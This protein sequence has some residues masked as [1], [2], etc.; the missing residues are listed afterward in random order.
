[1]SPSR[2]APE[3]PDK[4]TLSKLNEM[5]RDPE[6]YSDE[7]IAVYLREPD[8]KQ[9]SSNF[10]PALEV[11]TDLVDD[12]G[13]EADVA[14]A[15]LNRADRARRH[16]R[17]RSKIAGGYQGIRIV[18]EGDSWFQYPFILKDTIDWLMEAYAVY[19]LGAAGDLVADM[20]LQDEMRDAI[21]QHRPDVF[22]ISGGGNDLLGDGRLKLAVKTYRAGRPASEYPNANFDASIRDVIADYRRIFRDLTQEFPDL[23]II[24]HGYDY[25]LP[26]NGRWLGKPLAAKGITD[27]MLQAGIIAEMI[28]RF[29]Q[30]LA[31]LAQEFPGRVFR[32]NCRGAVGKNDWHDELHPD[33]KG[34]AAVANRFHA[35]IESVAG[36]VEAERAKPAPLSPGYDKRIAGAKDLDPLSFRELVDHRARELLA[37]PIE[38]TEDEDERRHIE[39]EIAQHFE[40]ISGGADFLPAGFLRD[41]A[42]RA[43]AVCRISTPTS[44]G[45]GFLVATRDFVMTNNHVLASEAEA[46]ESVAEF[47]LEHD[48]TGVRVALQPKRFFVTDETLDFTIVACD[49]SGVPADV[50]PIPLL[51]S[52]STVTRG[53]KVNIVQHPRGRPKEVA[54]HNNDVMRVK[55]V[56]IHYSTDTEPGSSGSPVFNNTWDLVALHHAGWTSAGVTT[57]EGVRIAAIVSHLIG[58]QTRESTGSVGIGELLGTIPDCSPHLGFFDVAGVVGSD[59]REVELPE[60]RGSADFADVGFWNIE[61][62]NGSAPDERVDRVAEVLGHLSLDAIGLCEV[63]RDAM[64]RLVAALQRLGLAYSYKYFDVAGGQDLAVLY[65]SRTTGVTI[66][67]G[68]LNRHRDAWAATTATGRT[69]FPRR[70]LIARVKVAP[71]VTDGTPGSAREVEFILIGLHL[72]AFGDP[73][74]RA[75]RRLAAQIL[76]EVIADIRETEKLPIVLG[77][78]LNETLNTDILSPLTDA[79][80][81]LTLT[82]DDADDNA[83]SY[84]GARYRSLIDHIIVSDDVTISPISGDDAAIIRL[85][86]SVRD[87]AADVSDHVPLVM[88]M[89]N[90]PAPIQVDGDGAAG[91]T[92]LSGAIP[93]GATSIRLTFE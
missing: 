58:R 57:N 34:Y 70:P 65:D 42:K 78:D 36:R 8:P 89:V 32:V 23:R 61:N 5:L 41:G 90:R 16:R 37:E 87:F 27:R 79:P 56:V 82:S 26:D 24:C 84:V 59:T 28:D 91:G 76:R 88:R 92:A 49:S 44:Y 81:L 39:A 86:R 69:A 30:A 72:K 85:D 55:D 43:D 47:G 83:L 22:L 14:I 54:L 4:I 66:S 31:D 18:S 29:N 51:R 67:Q 53:E 75:R 13:L 25:A 93:E 35:L 1:M 3:T 6:K 50:A 77:G 17:Y 48:E 80:D 38:P 9:G 64:D 52:P 15:F 21:R 68:I 40:K 2:P 46:A 62:F 11:N 7:E 73:E 10:A 33:K 12:G 71:Q 19:S 45:S 74:S 63:A 20:V 60:F